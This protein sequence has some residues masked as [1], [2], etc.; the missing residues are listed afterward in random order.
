MVER[1][2]KKNNVISKQFIIK[3][4]CETEAYS[5]DVPRHNTQQNKRGKNGAQRKGAQGIRGENYTTKTFAILHTVLFSST[6][7]VSRCLLSS[8]LRWWTADWSGSLSCLENEED[9]VGPAPS[10]GSSILDWLLSVVV[11]VK[12]QTHKFSF[13]FSHFQLARLDLRKTVR[14]VH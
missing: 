8:P 7:L 3:F 2:L 4:F 12:R 11:P 9:T 14:H 5:S 13:P 6:S 1:F 10:I